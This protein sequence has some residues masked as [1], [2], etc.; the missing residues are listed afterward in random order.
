MIES[1]RLYVL[2]PCGAGR[3]TP[4]DAHDDH[5]EHHVAADRP[6]LVR[7]S[8]GSRRL[9]ES[10]LSFLGLGVQPSQQTWGSL[11]QSGYA[12]IRIDAWQAIAPGVCIFAA[13][14]SLNVLGDSLRDAVDPRLRITTGA[15]R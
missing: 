15:G 5:A 11:L 9:Q 12:L 1:N 10:A 13:G 4:C 7:G 14:W 6:D 2:H 8:R 3:A